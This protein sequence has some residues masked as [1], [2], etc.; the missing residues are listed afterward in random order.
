MWETFKLWY[1]TYT[2]TFIE[3]QGRLDGAICDYTQ[4]DKMAFLERLSGFGVVNIEMES[5]LLTAL[6]NKAGI[7]CK[8]RPRIRWMPLWYRELLK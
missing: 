6:C 5:L 2:Y 7:S 3:G 1:N 4:D 8:S